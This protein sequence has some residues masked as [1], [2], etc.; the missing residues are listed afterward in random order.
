MC[1]GVLIFF[2]SGN[3]PGCAA[4]CAKLQKS[5]GY[6]RTRP[7]PRRRHLSRSHRGHPAKEH[8]S[9]RT[10][11]MVIPQTDGF[12]PRALASVSRSPEGQRRTRA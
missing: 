12:S 9:A 10:K 11:A 5:A 2:G 8:G 3:E 7:M 4:S 1:D 6:G